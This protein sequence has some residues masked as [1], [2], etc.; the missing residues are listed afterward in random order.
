M[1]VV[2]QGLTDGVVRAT[3]EAGRRWIESVPGQVE[4]LCF[5]WGLQLA[6][7]PPPC[8]DWNLI[9]FVRRDNDPCVLKIFGPEPSTADEVTALRAWAGRGAVLPLEVSRDGRAVLLEQLDPTRSLRDVEL[10]NAAETAGSLIRRLAVPAP[11]DLP[12]LTDIAQSH[13]ET[14][15]LRQQAQGKPL[16]SR[17]VDL[18]TQLAE[19]LAA[20]AGTSL[21]HSDLHY[22]NVL[23]AARE[24]WLAIDPKPVTGNP[25]RSV[26]EL[27]WNRIDDAPDAA[28]VNELFA[29]LITGGNLDSHRAWAWTIVQT[30]HYWL[31]GLNAGL[32]EDPIRCHRLL[33]TLA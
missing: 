3:G 5:K 21:V 10:M 11:P 28:A 33:D 26:P 12:L 31:W 23:A 16:P 17:W 4:N 8:G 7:E 22:G 14:L 20:D 29:A 2:P 30:V 25:E 1:I 24:P 32:T 18:A 13:V 15:A 6:E 19:E 9:L 27:M